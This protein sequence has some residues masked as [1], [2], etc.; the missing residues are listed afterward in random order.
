MRKSGKQGLQQLK[1][2]GSIDLRSQIH[3]K[4]VIIDE[5][6][7]WFGSLNPLSHTTKTDETMQRTEGHQYAKQLASFVALDPVRDVSKTDG[8]SVAKENPNCPS[9]RSEWVYLGETG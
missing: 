5:Q 6:I 4:I 2:V 9:C 8:I 7:V 1:K 3:Q